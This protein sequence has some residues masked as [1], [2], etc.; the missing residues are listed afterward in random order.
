MQNLSSAAAV[1]G[2]YMVKIAFL[3]LNINLLKDASNV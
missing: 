2:A 3:G 1:I